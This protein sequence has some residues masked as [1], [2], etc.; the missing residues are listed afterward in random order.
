[1]RERPDQGGKEMWGLNWGRKQRRGGEGRGGDE[2]GGRKGRKGG[3]GCGGRVAG[4]ERRPREEGSGG[5][6][7]R[8]MAEAGTRCWGLGF[9]IV[10]DDPGEARWKR[11]GN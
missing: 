2:N 8:G 9:G 3:N 11:R 1:M 4:G 10:D 5:C 7:R 6:G